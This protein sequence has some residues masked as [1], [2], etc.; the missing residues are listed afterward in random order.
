MANG[1]LVGVGANG[2]VCIDVGTV[3]GASGR[4]Q[5]IVDVVGYLAA[6]AAQS[7]TRQ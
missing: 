1:A 3:D 4:S 2:Q 5:V 7:A 6:P